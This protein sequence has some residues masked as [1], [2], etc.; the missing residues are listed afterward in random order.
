MKEWLSDKRESM[1]F[2]GIEGIER[3]NRLIADFIVNSL[4]INDEEEN[5]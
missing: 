5:D 4:E 3:K 1:V 2:G